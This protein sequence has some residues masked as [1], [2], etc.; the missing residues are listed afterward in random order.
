MEYNQ[1]KNMD[2]GLNPDCIVL[3]LSS[4]CIYL[5]LQGIPT[6]YIFGVV[7]VAEHW[8]FVIKEMRGKLLYAASLNNYNIVLNEC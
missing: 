1:S 4:Q 5:S 7:A 2:V 8:N 6:A 3:E